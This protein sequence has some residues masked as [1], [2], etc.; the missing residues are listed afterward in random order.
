MRAVLVMLA[1]HVSAQMAPQAQGPPPPTGPP[2]AV[3][4]IVNMLTKMQDTLI[5]E[6]KKDEE[7]YEKMTCWCTVNRKEKTENIEAAERAIDQYTSTIEEKTALTAQLKTE[8][9]QLKEEMEKAQ[10]A[11]D[12]A[13]A[14]REE[15]HA[16]FSKEEQELI[17]T[18]DALTRAVE[19]LGKHHGESLL[20][21]QSTL[22]RLSLGSMEGLK[23]K[24]LDLLKQPAGYK[25][26]NS[27]SGEIFG[28]LQQMKETFE[29]DLSKE[30]KDE[31]AAQQRF[32]ELVA[33]KKKGIEVAR[34][35]KNTKVTELSEAEIALVNAKHDLKDTRENL[36]ADQKFVVDLEEKCAMSDKEYEERTK[37]RQEEV[38]AIGDA[39]KILT[40]D[41]AR[42]LFSSSLGFTQVRATK[43]SAARDHVV[44]ILR[45]AARK[46]DNAQLALLATSAQLDAFTKVKAAIDEMI[47]ELK[48]QQEDE[49]QHKRWCQDELRK[50]EVEHKEKGWK[51]EDLA[52]ANNV[53]AD[54]M[55]TLDGEMKALRENVAENKRQ[56]KR[57]SEDREAANNEF[58]QVVAD[59]RA[60]KAILTK[61]LERLQEVYAPEELAA[62]RAAAT[63]TPA[64]I[65]FLQT[66]LTHRQPEGF[67]SG[68]KQSAGGVLGLIEMTIADAER[69]QKESV[70]AEQ[71]QQT[72][73]EKLVSDAAAEIA[74]DNK[75]I[76]DKT[77]ERAAAETEKNEVETSLEATKKAIEDLE[78]YATEV[79]AACD[80]VLKNFDLRQTARGDEIS[81]LEDAKAILSGADFG[82]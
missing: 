11:I 21:V 10:E 72:E 68:G 65:A 28:I 20:M 41:S 40:E 45:A 74:A 44:N 38:E 31:S 7:I 3:T 14:M 62:K 61:V 56:I 39:L 50:N 15:D 4:K 46:N 59:Q 71:T 5:D 82:F 53:L 8:I 16:E 34:E 70:E 52:K 63:S 18:V 23:Q 26:Y 25:S 47:A 17:E 13:T 19:V 43:S 2:K 1:M 69:L 64:P 36:S 37:S 67:G 32:E 60:T 54:T 80:F 76:V 81:A 51:A 30:Q 6:G 12:T 24:A 48:K 35:R 22:Q 29:Q 79:H 9:E 66:R 33:E 73:Y 55:E 57:A 27:R 75:A 42:D 58:Q 78:K 49:V 77:E